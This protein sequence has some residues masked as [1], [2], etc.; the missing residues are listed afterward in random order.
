MAGPITWRNVESDPTRGA[1]VL[2]ESA[3]RSLNDGFKGFNGIIDSRNEVNQQNWDTQK[4]VNTDQFLDRLAQYKTPEELAAAQEAGQLQALKAQFGGQID[5]DAVRGAEAAQADVLMKR[6]AAQNQYGDDKINRDARPDAAVFD[7]L[8]AAGKLKEAADW[9]ASRV[10]GTDESPFTN[11]LLERGDVQFNQ[12]NTKSQ[13]AISQRQLGLDI[14]RDQR[15]TKDWEDQWAETTQRRVAIDLGDQALNGAAD[16][17]SA[18]SAYLTSAKEKGLR[19]DVVNAGLEALQKSYQTRTGLTAE[20]D[21]LLSSDSEVMA[22]TKSAELAKEQLT[23][24]RYSDPKAT[25]V[26]EDEAIANIFPRV[27]GEEDETSNL[28]KTH[29]KTFKEKHK[30]SLEAAGITNLGPV[31]EQALKSSG[32]DEA[33]LGDDTMD[34][35]GFQS[36]MTNALSDYVAYTELRKQADT[37]SS[38]AATKRME[39][40]LQMIQG[41]ILKNLK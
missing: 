35:N 3:R 31:V 33:L 5:R 4:E 22:M 6:I 41:N 2:F 8:V 19:D 29:L 15:E 1:A 9:K 17:A 13:L 25:K 36:K 14:A 11:R 32:V 16:F 40:Q 37:A 30:G 27:K 10:L 38:K 24:N 7:D 20:Q 23:K 39:K 18:R 28:I 26:T 12:D 21:A 34:F